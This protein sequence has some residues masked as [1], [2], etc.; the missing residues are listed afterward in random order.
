[1]QLAMKI[2]TKFKFFNSNN[3]FDNVTIA[4]FAIFVLSLPFSESFISISSGL[5]L[6]VQLVLSFFRK[7]AFSAVKDSSFWLVSSI[8]LIYVIGFLF[9]K[10]IQF[11]LYELKKAVFWLVLSFGVILSP[12]LSTKNFWFIL[13]LFVFG[14]TV[15]TFFSFFKLIF[16]GALG[17]ENFRAV[18]FV[19]HIPFSFQISFSIFILFFSFFYD[20]SVLKKLNPAIRIVWIIW[21][22]FS[23]IV[24]KS[25]LGIAAFFVSLIP[26]SVFIF[27]SIRLNRYRNALIFAMI[28]L[29]CL[30]AFYVGWAIGKF[31]D[32]KYTSVSTSDSDLKTKQGNDYQFDFSKKSKE[33]GYYISWFVC[34][35]ELE[36]A[37]NEVSEI[38]YNQPDKSG[39]LVSE[40][41]KRYLTSKGLRKD[42]EGVNCLTKR[43]IKNIEAGY[44]NYIYDAPYYAIYP[45]VYETIWEVDHYLQTG[46][47]NDQ[48]LSQRIEYAKAAL[49]IIKNN[50]WFGIGTGNFQIEFEKAFKERNSC[51][52]EKFYGSAHNQYLSY[53]LKF[54]LVGFLYIMFVV[55]F[56]VYKKRLYRNQLFLI[57]FFYMLVANFG[58]SNW[59]T[60]VGLPYFVFFTCLFAWHSPEFVRT[61]R[62]V[63]Q[64]RS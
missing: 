51:L 47:A 11:G 22:L 63:D 44:A 62:F 7:N 26:L 43:D 24:L 28:L 36:V 4:L 32:I 16:H 6:L 61:K 1:M 50:F 14:V 35:P 9:T 56:V 21:L 17:I 55:F 39:Y 42:A 27:K 45:R 25:M 30:P 29:F 19:S 59:E 31:Y 34:E 20:N 8:F 46:D 52:N 53:L 2:N 57:F 38:K 41:L 18:N 58:D 33:N 5:I 48:S 10:D 60:H 64:I 13:T 15:S 23:L 54:G 12:K 40:T 49:D 37:W 3:G